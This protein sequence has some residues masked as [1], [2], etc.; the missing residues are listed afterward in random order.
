MNDEQQPLTADPEVVRGWLTHLYGGCPGLL[1]ICS[2]KDGWVG[3]RFATDGPGIEAAVQYVSERDRRKAKGVYAQSTTLR[4]HPPVGPDGKKGRGGEDLAFGLTHL[5]ADGDYGTIGH[6]PGPDDLPAPPDA[7]SVAKVV[8]ESGL[9]TPSGWVN[10][11]GGYNPVWL[12]AEN[13]LIQNAEDSARV[14]AVT[15]GVQAILAAEAYRHGWSWDVEVGNL[16]RLMKVPG[17][18]N[19]KEGLERPTSVGPGTGEVFEWTDLAATVSELAPAARELLGQAGR[20][21]QE[22]KAQRTGVPT[23][24]PQRARPSGLHS[25]D[26][27]LDVLA[28]MLTFK[29]ILEPEGWTYVGQTG[30]REKWLRPTAGGDGPSSAYS[31]LCDD[32]V[33]VNWSERSDL[34]VGAQPPGQKLTVGTLYAH[35]HYAGNTSEAASDIM[36]AAAGRPARGAAGRL[37]PAVLTE[38]KRRCM[39]DRE[40]NHDDADDFRAS[41]ADDPWD[42]VQ[43]E[44]PEDSGEAPDQPADR[45]PDTFWNATAVLQQIRQMARARRA[46]P[47]GVLHAVLARTAAMADPT[48]RVD[49]GIHQPATLG[50]YCG[51]FGPSGSGKGNA[52]N[53]AEELTPFPAVDLA[54]I[55]ISTG[56]GL[57]AAYLDLAIDPDDEDGKKKI[58]VQKRNRGYA[59]A[60]EG[61]VLD[62][63]AQMSAAATLNGVLCKAWMSERQGTS[64][65]EVE[66]RR[67][68]PK[69][70]YTLS[71]SLGVQEEPAAKLLEMGS[72]G[73]PQRLAWAHATLGPDTPDKRPTTTRPVMVTKQDGEDVP[74]TTWVSGLR[75]TTIPVPGHVTDE[76]DQLALEISFGR[77]ADAPLDTHEPLWRLKCAALLAL[78]HGRTSVKAEDWDRATVMWETSRKVR[79]RVQDAA[80]RRT[81][82]ELDAR[83]AEAVRTAAE[84]QAAVYEVVNGVHPSV[85]NVAKRAHRYV[86]RHGGE[87]PVRDV[88]RNCIKKPDRDKY[89]ASGATDSLWSAALQYGSEQG[90]L[91]LLAGGL[92]AAGSVAPE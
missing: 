12:L 87:I 7:D 52:E 21:K 45:I 31:L 4:E 83:R 20:E 46:S 69:G 68:L 59:L 53:T 9:P 75:G 57:I 76:L 80:R 82:A 86:T 61:S 6:K 26:G 11:G 65:A 60:T 88:N 74:V 66:R 48:V 18:P 81:Q 77:G 15:T 47:D 73:L 84:S 42:G 1:S 44:P 14:K 72:I 28:D 71:M 16:D 33:A 17:P 40:R 19:R 37:A 50:W 49:S 41:L 54:Y 56:Q 35:L 51:L 29:D 38:V 27:P 10:T 3:R 2:D 30:G 58:L 55:D 43:D 79:D 62:A 64:N 67:A 22:R 89:R 39:K 90:W 92:L 36:R 23:A 34:P 70:R 63:M 13:Y 25:G 91:V 78:L 32:H 24:S 8:A 85:E 5:W